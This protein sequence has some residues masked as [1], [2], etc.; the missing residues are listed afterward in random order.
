MALCQRR[1]CLRDFVLVGVFLAI[2]GVHDT[3]SI[4]ER[5]QAG[6][7]GGFEGRGGGK[8]GEICRDFVVEIV[9]GSQT[10][11]N[12]HITIAASGSDTTIVIN[13][14]GAGSMPGAIS[15]PLCFFIGNC[16]F[17]VSSNWMFKQKQGNARLIG[18]SLVSS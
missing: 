2:T 5:L 1:F 16:F 11:R 8:Q 15:T 9:A 13:P 4:L 3:R 6:F 18:R 7:Q 10:P 12:G 14:P 17:T